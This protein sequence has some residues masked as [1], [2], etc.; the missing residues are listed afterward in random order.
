MRTTYD[1]TASG[2]QLTIGNFA[3]SHDTRPWIEW[4]GGWFLI[5]RT[6]EEMQ[7]ADQA[8]IP[9]EATMASHDIGVFAIFGMFEEKLSSGPPHD[10]IFDCSRPCI[11]ELD[12]GLFG[13]LCRVQR[14]PWADS[15]PSIHILS[16]K[17]PGHVGCELPALVDR[18]SE[19]L[20]GVQEYKHICLSSGSRNMGFRE[21][22]RR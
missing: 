15:L 14:Q 9:A 5:H 18:I 1:A 19:P 17:L 13:K 21:I 11:A 2:D 7:A 20:S 8:G 12:D 22:R 3:D 6:Q 4:C 16:G 10:A